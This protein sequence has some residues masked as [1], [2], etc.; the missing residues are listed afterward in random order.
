MKH[1]IYVQCI[2]LLPV[3]GFE[4]IKCKGIQYVI[5]D[6]KRHLTDFVTTGLHHLIHII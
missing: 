6:L 2:F 1:A 5:S 4:V 3:T